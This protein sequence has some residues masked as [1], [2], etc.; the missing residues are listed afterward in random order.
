MEQM[1]FPPTIRDVA[2]VTTCS[3]LAWCGVLGPGE[4]AGYMQRLCR[5][6]DIKLALTLIESRV[7]L[8]D[9]LTCLAYHGRN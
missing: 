9:Y 3:N 4:V 7:Q 2:I 8:D 5:L 6:S 1:I